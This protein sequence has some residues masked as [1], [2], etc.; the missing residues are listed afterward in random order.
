MQ[1]EIDFDV[2]EKL[3]TDLEVKKLLNDLN[4]SFSNNKVVTDNAK[5]ILRTDRRA[6][7]PPPPGTKVQKTYNQRRVTFLGR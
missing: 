3:S 4:I 6:I 7:L 1:D 5:K 2:Y